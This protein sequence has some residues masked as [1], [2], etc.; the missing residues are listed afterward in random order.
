MPLAVPRSAG[1][2]DANRADA[3]RRPARAGMER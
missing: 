3:A 1:N 2:A